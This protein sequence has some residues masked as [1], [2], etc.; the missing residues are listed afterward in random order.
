[1]LG[2]MEHGMDPGAMYGDDDSFEQENE[3]E[4]GTLAGCSPEDGCRDHEDGEEKSEPADGLAG[5]LERG[6]RPLGKG[7]GVDSCLKVFAAGG[8]VFAEVEPVAEVGDGLM[9][10]LDGVQGSRFEQPG[11]ERV[12][13]H[14]GA[15]DGEEREEAAVPKEIEIGGIEVFGDIETFSALASALP[16]VFDTRDSSAVEVDG[17]F[18]DSLPLQDLRVIDSD[19]DKEQYRN[20]EPDRSKAVR[21]EIDPEERNLGDNQEEAK[22]AEADVNGLKMLD[23][24]LASFLTVQVLLRWRSG[25]RH[26]SLLLGGFYT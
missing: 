18:S 7:F 12:F 17:T 22:I 20:C 19:Y 9:A 26:K 3:E 10:L 16:T 11:G 15:C 23:L 2:L 21:S 25:L 8:H 5:E 14:A 6:L 4:G 1:M 13:A 24:E